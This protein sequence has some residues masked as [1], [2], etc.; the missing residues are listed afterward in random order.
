MSNSLKKLKC[1]T[2]SCNITLDYFFECQAVRSCNNKKR[3]DFLDFRLMQLKSRLYFF[4]Q[5]KIIQIKT[6][7][8]SWVQNWYTRRQIK[9]EFTEHAIEE[10]KNWINSINSAKMTLQ[11]AIDCDDILI[12]EDCDFI[13]GKIK[14][15]NK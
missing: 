3:N 2:G 1:F 6:A 14:K 9:E 15:K 8:F 7:T 10:T 5:I 4:V 11:F 12:S 13:G